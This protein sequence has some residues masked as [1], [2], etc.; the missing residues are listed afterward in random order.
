MLFVEVFCSSLPTAAAADG[1]TAATDADN[2]SA[3]RQLLG[4]ECHVTCP[5]GFQLRQPIEI[6]TCRY[7]GRA[8]W[9]PAAPPV[10]YGTFCFVSPLFSP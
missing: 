6:Y 8:L 2:C 7:D 1:I 5:R 10:C 4:S 3:T 9:H